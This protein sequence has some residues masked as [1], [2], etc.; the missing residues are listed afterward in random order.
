M[1]NA[2]LL[3]K[4]EARYVCEPNSGCWLWTGPLNIYGYAML[5]VGRRRGATG[6][7]G[8]RKVSR[9]LY[10]MLNNVVLTREEFICHR[11][12]TPACVRPD[13]LFLGNAAINNI[14][15]MNKGRSHL[16]NG[17]RAGEKNHSTKLTEA[18]VEKIRSLWPGVSS[19]KLGK[20]FGVTKQAILAIVHER[21][22][23]P[24][25]RENRQRRKK[26]A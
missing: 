5:Y 22:W 1:T 17:S 4:I 10:E 24:N 13:H 21:A 6:K 9:V 11:C 2:D 19:G 18:K 3:P 26:T 25:W 15:R 8:Q 23:S 7:N 12:D 16:W 14:D 20:R